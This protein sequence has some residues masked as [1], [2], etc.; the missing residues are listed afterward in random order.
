MSSHTCIAL[1]LYALAP[2][3]RTHAH[4]HGQSREVQG[5]GSQ[6]GARTRA[7]AKVAIGNGESEQQR[8]GNGWRWR[9]AAEADLD[10]HGRVRTPAAA[11]AFQGAW[12]WGWLGSGSVTTN[13]ARRLN[14]RGGSHLR[15]D[16]APSGVQP[17]IRRTTALFFILFYFMC[18]PHPTR[19]NVAHPDPYLPYWIGTSGTSTSGVCTAAALLE[20]H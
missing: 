15:A 6:G 20:N 7:R 5:R 9:G 2:I 8:C 4:A 17:S 19:Q 3:T 12:G 16:V 11:H 18:R 1:I 10:S 14:R 13:S